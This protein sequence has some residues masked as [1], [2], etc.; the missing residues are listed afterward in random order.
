[1][2]KN[3]QPQSS[4]MADNFDYCY[5]LSLLLIFRKYD[6]GVLLPSWYINLQ[7]IFVICNTVLVVEYAILEH[8]CNRFRISGAKHQI[9]VGPNLD[10]C[11]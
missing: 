1:M 9:L 3:S 11:G 6:E 8:I 2:K 10:N 4:A 5:F 7:F